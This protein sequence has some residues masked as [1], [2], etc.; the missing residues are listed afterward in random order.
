M[1]DPVG[2]TSW[3]SNSGCGD[4]DR[5]KFIHCDDGHEPEVN[6][7]WF[8]GE[9]GVTPKFHPTAQVDVDAGLVCNFQPTTSLKIGLRHLL[10]AKNPLMEVLSFSAFMMH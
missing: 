6:E 9:D 5:S 10:S 8:L 2:A 7:V 3:T 4:D 1:P